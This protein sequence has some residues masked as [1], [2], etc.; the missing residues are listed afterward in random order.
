MQRSGEINQTLHTHTL[1]AEERYT[2]REG[3]REV[4]HT[5]EHHRHGRG[6]FFEARVRVYNFSGNVPPGQF[7]FPFA[8]TV[9]SWDCLFSP[10]LLE[11]WL[12]FGWFQLPRGLPG[13]FNAQSHHRTEAHIECELADFA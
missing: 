1:L 5:R 2:V 10:H 9:C 4:Q 7:A 11:H 8:F 13:V 3:E 6:V 12:K